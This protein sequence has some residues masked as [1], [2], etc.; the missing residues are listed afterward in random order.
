[1]LATIS[2]LLEEQTWILVFPSAK[3]AGNGVIPLSHAEYKEQSVSNAMAP[4]S[5]N[6]TENLVDAAKLILKLTHLD[7]KLKRASYA[8]IHSNVPTAKETTKP[9]PTPACFG[10]ITS[11]ENGMWKSTLRSVRTGHNQFILK[12][13]ASLTN[14]CAKS[15]NFFTKCSQE[16][17]YH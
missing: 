11:I 8:P 13:T 7:W 1:M 3:T 12:W 17:T 2:L 4:T 14:D 10:D 9:T 5:P 16:L 15:Q 6:T